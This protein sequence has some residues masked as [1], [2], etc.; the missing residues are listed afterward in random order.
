VASHSDLAIVRNY[1]STKTAHVQVKQKNTTK[2][3]LRIR[4]QTSDQSLFWYN[5]N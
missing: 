2:A 1:Y 4:I 5:V 3:N